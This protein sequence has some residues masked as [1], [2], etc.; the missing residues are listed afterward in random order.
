MKEGNFFFAAQ[1]DS[2]SARKGLES[3]QKIVNF[4]EFGRG[5]RRGGGGE[6]LFLLQGNEKYLLQSQDSE[7]L[8]RFSLLLQFY[9]FGKCLNWRPGKSCSFSVPDAENSD[10]KKRSVSVRVRPAELWRFFSVRAIISGTCRTWTARGRSQR[11]GSAGLPGTW[12][13]TVDWLKSKADK[14]GEISAR[15]IRSML[16]RKKLRPT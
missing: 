4:P 1:E 3:A 13:E 16:P 14:K 15:G 12:I 5:T 2:L 8:L 9:L 7:K 10:K 6:R 11:N